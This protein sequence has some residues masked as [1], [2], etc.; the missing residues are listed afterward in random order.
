M[1]RTRLLVALVFA[2]AAIAFFSA[3][4]HRYFSFDNLKAQQAALEG[5]RDA[6]PWATALGFFALYVA[7]TSL[8]LPAASI[9]TVLAGAIF[10]IGLGVLLVSF[11][12]A[13]GATVAMLAARFVLRDWVQ[14]RFGARLQAL[15]R[16][17]ER[18]GAFYL[19]TLR[20][21]PA[22]PYFLINLAMGLTPIRTGT[23]YWVSQLAMFPATVIYV[24]A[25]TQLARL[26][27]GR[28]I[29]SWQLLG[30]L[31]LLGIFPLAAKKVVDLAKARRVYA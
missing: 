8:S 12:S 23:F 28:D 7:F 20:L 31:L 26:E 22:F 21:V 15:N 2:A 1:S 29:L 30:A 18:E 11:A 6:H 5:W 14:Q 25:G 10:G 17:V 9:M 16:G 19:F 24:N 4:G 3:G 27:S 13:I